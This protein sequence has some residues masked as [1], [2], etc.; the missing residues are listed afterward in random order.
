MW[1]VMS[2]VRVMVDRQTDIQV[3][4]MH[5]ASGKRLSLTLTCTC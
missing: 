4:S 3:Q 1:K 5:V 2:R